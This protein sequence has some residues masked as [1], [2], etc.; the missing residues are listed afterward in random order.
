MNGT[1]QD[2]PTSNVRAEASTANI[3][4]TVGPVVDAKVGTV[5]SEADAS[6][7]VGAVFDHGLLGFPG[8]RRFSLS[9]WGSDDGPFALMKSVDDSAEFLVADP[10]AFFPGYE[11]EID[12]ETADWLGISTPEDAEVLVIISVPDQ[13]ENATANLLGP[14]VINKQT[15]RS[16]QMVLNDPWGTR[17]PIFQVSSARE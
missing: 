16:V 2:K 4:D 8:T 12:S 9:P 3:V 1:M 10:D 13:A 6:D 15:R 17:H 11:P 14:L 7:T 5:V